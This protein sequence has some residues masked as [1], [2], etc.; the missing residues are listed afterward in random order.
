MIANMRTVIDVPDKL[1]E[2]LDQLGGAAQ[3]S[4]AA[5]IR[6]AIADFLQRK[7]VPRA[8]AAFGLWSRRKK[9]GVRFQEEVRG[10]WQKQ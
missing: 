4:R 2:S 10:E 7:S 1:I 5:L 9:D 8:E 3:I 6:E